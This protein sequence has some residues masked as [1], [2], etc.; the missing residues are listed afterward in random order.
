[1]FLFFNNFFDLCILRINLEKR[2]VVIR[3]IWKHHEKTQIQI[4]FQHLNMNSTTD[5]LCEYLVKS[6]YTAPSNSTF[7]LYN[8]IWKTYF[9]PEF[10]PKSRAKRLERC[11]LNV[12]IHYRWREDDTF[13]TARTLAGEF[14]LQA[15]YTCTNTFTLP[16]K[17]LGSCGMWE[18]LGRENFGGKNFSK[19]MAGNVGKKV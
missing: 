15:A 3:T 10:V 4:I 9:S 12:C 6:G 8:I 5:I 14:I 16:F 11:H 13:L 1:M 17:H 7:F 18:Y 19:G 2:R